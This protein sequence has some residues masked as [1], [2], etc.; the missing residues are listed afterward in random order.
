M[1]FQYNTYYPRP[2]FQMR[3]KDTKWAVP[4]ALAVVVLLFVVLEYFLFIPVT[5]R[6]PNFL[7][8]LALLILVFDALVFILKSGFQK[9]QRYLLYFAGLLFVIVIAGSL[10]SAPIFHAHKYQQQLAMNEDADFYEDITAISFNQIPVVDRDSATRL[11]DR[12]MGE[13]MDYVSQFDVWPDYTQINYHGRPVR[14]TPLGYSGLIK[15]FN[16][17][18]EGLPAY[19]IVDMVNQEADIKRLDEK[20]KYSESDLFFRDVRRHLFTRYPTRM[21]AEVS[22]EIDEEGIP[23]YVAP[24]YEYKIGLF[25]GKDI[26]GAV[27]LNAINGDTQYYPIDEVPTWLDRV[28]P[29]SLVVSQLD[30]WGKYQN[31]F[32]NSYFG[33]RG[34][35]KSTDGYNYITIDDDVYLYTGLTSV[36]ADESNVGF[37]LINLRTKEAKFYNIPGA[38][39]YSA[40]ESA[41]GQV[42]DLH[43][44]ATF[45]ILINSGGEPTYF[46]ALKDSAGLVKQYA[47]VSVTNYNIV[48]TGVSVAEAQKNYFQALSAAGQAVTEGELVTAQGTVTRIQNVVVEGNTRVYFSLGDGKVYIASVTLDDRLPLLTAGDQVEVSYYQTEGT[49]VSVQSI[50][51]LSEE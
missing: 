17:F 46:M 41:M 12:K 50:A 42:Q 13:I 39:E 34:V 27:L 21:F 9:W 3:R 7:L 15:W 36:L 51:F 23:Y 22:F 14:V 33:Q 40:M 5:I 16:N 19:I 24:V 4:I 29:E 25:G 43:Y 2:R 11:G 8:F 32:L 35:L 30:N 26:V 28:Y 20:M 47:F 38:E 37:A 49:S 31:G 18:R 48:A 1:R 45:P 44:Q 6:N 10:I